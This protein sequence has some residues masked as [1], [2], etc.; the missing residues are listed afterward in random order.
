MTTK[1]ELIKMLNQLPDNYD[2]Y[3]RYGEENQVSDIEFEF[4]CD[5]EGIGEFYLIRSNGENIQTGTFDEK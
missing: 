5:D 2:I 1:Q 3:T 4:V